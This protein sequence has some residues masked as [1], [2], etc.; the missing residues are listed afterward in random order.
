VLCRMTAAGE[1]QWLPESDT[2]IRYLI[3]T[4]D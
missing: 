4:Y 2:I 1:T 3:Q